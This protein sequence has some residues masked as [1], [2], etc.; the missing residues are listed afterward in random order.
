MTVLQDRPRANR[1]EFWRRLF[2]HRSATLGLVIVVI[3]SMVAVFAPHI[4]PHDPLKQDILSALSPPSR[5]HPFGTDAMGRDLLSRVILGSR[6]SVTVGLVVV[7]VAGTTGILAGLVAAYFEGWVDNVISR[8]IDLLLAFPSFL[9]ALSV[10]TILGPSLINAMLA[11]AIAT[12]PS[13]ARVARG[14]AL[15]EKQKDHILAARVIG[16]NNVGI[17]FRHILPNTLAP[18]IVLATVSLAT[19]ILTTASLSF[20]GLGAQPPT[21]EWGAIL[22]RGR[23]YMR[24]AWWLTVFPGMAIA[25][26]VLA[27]NLLG[28]GLRDLLDPRLRHRG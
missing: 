1:W 13:F 6:I 19:A 11:V 10:L 8:F 14:A 17:I 22:A 24:V 4:M 26:S 7:L 15:S 2:R 28:D 18:L 12:I 5:D 20:L 16:V 3:V 21:P 23:E 25:I 9:L 27:L